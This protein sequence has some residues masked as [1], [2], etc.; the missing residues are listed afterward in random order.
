MLYVFAIPVILFFALVFF[1]TYE[2]MK[3]DERKGKSL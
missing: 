3:S 1:I 2:K